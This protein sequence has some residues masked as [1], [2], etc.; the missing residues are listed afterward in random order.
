M[1]FWL[2]LYCI[3]VSGTCQQFVGPVMPHP[4]QLNTHCFT[5][6][7]LE[8][9]GFNPPLRIRMHNFND[10]SLAD[11]LLNLWKHFDENQIALSVSVVA[12]LEGMMCQNPWQQG[13]Q[14]WVHNLC[15]LHYDSVSIPLT[16][17]D[18]HM[19]NFL[20]Q[21]TGVPQTTINVT[22]SPMLGGWLFPATWCGGSSLC[23][24]L[25]TMPTGFQTKNNKSFTENP[26]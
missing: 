3:N 7:W 17:Y 25:N 16:G 13:Q 19:L 4:T 11:I 20:L 14:N 2:I 1:L 18:L 15:H 5:V 22:Q 26:W 8:P 24:M 10:M 12:Y 23:S 9:R 21:L 6:P